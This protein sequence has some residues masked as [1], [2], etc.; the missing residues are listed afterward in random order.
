MSEGGDD[1][2]KV[3]WRIVAEIAGKNSVDFGIIDESL[4]CL[5]SVIKTM[6]TYIS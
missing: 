4:L 3:T 1:E 6:V 5:F 2:G